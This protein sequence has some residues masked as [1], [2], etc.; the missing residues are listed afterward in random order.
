[1][2]NQNYMV[3]QG[4]LININTNETHQVIGVNPRV[5]LSYGYTIKGEKL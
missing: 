4:D 2:E 1:M 3:N 5:V